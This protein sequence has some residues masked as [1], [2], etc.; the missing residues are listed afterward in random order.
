MS[1]Q[2]IINKITTEIINPTIYLLFAAATA[3]FVWGIIQYII[4]AGQGQAQKGKNI[5]LYGLVG[6]FIMASAFGI[7]KIMC[8]FFGTQC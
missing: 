7:V 1:I 6:L 2:E 5:I 8:N 4:S 3:V